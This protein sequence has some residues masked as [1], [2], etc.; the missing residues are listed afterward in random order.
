MKAWGGLLAAVL[1]AAGE[2]QARYV[3]APDPEI[4]LRA[5][6]RE[7]KLAP[8]KNRAWLLYEIAPEQFRLGDPE[9]ARASLNAA[10]ESSP[11][12]SGCNR[13]T[14]LIM[15]ARAQWEAGLLS[16]A[17]ATFK[18]AF[19]D[20]AADELTSRHYCL[21]PLALA[22]A[23]TG[24][25]DWA[26][27]VA[28]AVPGGRKS[29]LFPDLGLAL[30]KQGRWDEAHRVADRAN[31]TWGDHGIYRVQVLRA[32]GGDWKEAGKFLEKVMQE[33]SRRFY[34]DVAEEAAEAG[35]FAKAEEALRLAGAQGDEYGHVARKLVRSLA[36]HGRIDEAVRK[37]SATYSD[38]GDHAWMLFEI[39]ELQRAAKD[40]GA[41]AT[42][43]AAMALSLKGDPERHRRSLMLRSGR[44][45]RLEEAFSFVSPGVF[46][47]A[48]DLS[49]L[50]FALIDVGRLDE[51]EVAA[52]RIQ[53][54]YLI[55]D[56]ERRREE[57][58]AEL[59]EARARHGDIAGVLRV[60]DAL[61]FKDY[62]CPDRVLAFATEAA[63]RQ[64]DFQRAVDL[65]A[66]RGGKHSY[67]DRLPLSQWAEWAAASGDYT[68]PTPW[69][70]RFPAHEDKA[71]IWLGAARG[72]SRRLRDRRR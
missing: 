71:A 53:T 60:C 36:M 63:A 18:T 40:P 20:G 59:A 55:S 5:A 25:T 13:A 50:T 62:G 29:D 24:L 3:H 34:A 15:V 49:S 61:S 12:W 65:K 66:E 2:S 56:T 67:S 22:L 69:L 23:E 48:T 68:D 58:W 1:L 33:P 70:L 30:A 47:Q 37:A 17:S 16:E 46:D 52:T 27:G 26:V 10:V 54:T 72:A 11:D 57:A 43:R 21:G 41:E 6:A 8:A 39:A 14:R 32:T 44:A 4:M 31:P 9:G 42:E 7:A 64:G 38:P 45:G 28:A 35:D 19:D 51:A